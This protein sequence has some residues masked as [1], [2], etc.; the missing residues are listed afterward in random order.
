MT[1]TAA[2]VRSAGRQ[3]A[4]CGAGDSMT[5][6]PDE[7]E[8]ICHLY[9]WPHKEQALCGWR[10][11]HTNFAPAHEFGGAVPLTRST[12]VKRCPRCLDLM[13]PDAKRYSIMPP[14]DWIPWEEA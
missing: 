2:N 12:D 5:Y 11:P 10:P 8:S 9:E 1:P 13:E 6:N 14:E 4:D 3:S 7:H